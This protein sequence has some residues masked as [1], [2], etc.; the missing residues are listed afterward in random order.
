MFKVQRSRFKV[1][2]AMFNV[3]GST[4]NVRGWE[5]LEL[6]EKEMTHA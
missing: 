5:A 2:G 3:Q 4:F 6:A 1:Q